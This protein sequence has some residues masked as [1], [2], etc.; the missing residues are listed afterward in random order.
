MEN[1]E[2]IVILLFLISLVVAIGSSIF[3][4]WIF[5][6]ILLVFIKDFRNLTIIEKI[7]AIILMLFL[8]G[9]AIYLAVKTAYVLYLLYKG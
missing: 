1:I 5:V 7:I 9:S 6:S 4:F 2:F 3:Y 8:L